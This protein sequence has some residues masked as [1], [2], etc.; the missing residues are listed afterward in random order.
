MRLPNAE[1]AEVDISKLRDYTLSPEHG[2]GSH[3]ARVFKA[4][5]GITKTDAEWLRGVLLQAAKEG[6]ARDGPPSPFGSK[7]LIDINL[8]RG[9]RSAPVRSVWIIEY[10]EEHPRLVTCYV[11]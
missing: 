10:G 4:A 11:P 7:Y 8:T 6:E 3:K 1:A 9:G 2:E 5:L